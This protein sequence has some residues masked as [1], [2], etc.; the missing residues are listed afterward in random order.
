MNTTIAEAIQNAKAKR[1]EFLTVEH[2]L[3]ALLN[4]AA[5]KD[6]L[7]EVGAELDSLRSALEEH[8]ENTTPLI[9]AGDRNQQ[10]QATLGFSRVVRRAIFHVQ[11][12]GRKEMTGANA[13]VAIFDEK[14]TAVYLLK[15]QNIERIDVV[16]TI[17]QDISKGGDEGEPQ[18]A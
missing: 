5:A 6:V 12:R 11:S 14:S 9:P 17:A 16:N 3:L 4:N 2:L 13:L 1:H 15:Q 10:T 18:H 8:I 7:L